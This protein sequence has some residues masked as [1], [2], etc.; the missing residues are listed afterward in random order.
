MTLPC[1]S[2][3]SHSEGSLILCPYTG[4]RFGQTCL[5]SGGGAS[6]PS[7]PEPPLCCPSLEARRSGLE[8]CGATWR[9][10]TTQ[11]EGAK[12]PPAPG[13]GRNLLAWITQQPPRL[14]PIPGPDALSAFSCPQSA[15]ETAPQLPYPH[16]G[17]EQSCG[18]VAT[19]MRA[20]LFEKRLYICVEQAISAQARHPHTW[21]LPH[22]SG[23][24][25][26][27]HPE[28]KASRVDRLL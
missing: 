17:W 4:A 21:H 16:A 26:K 24:L 28:I 18:S 3:T 20:D 10:N 11:C 23:T 25:S 14:E 12:L 9:S 22:S 2:T 19:M 6:P 15:S 7:D 13:R 5:R 8:D 27:L 1:D